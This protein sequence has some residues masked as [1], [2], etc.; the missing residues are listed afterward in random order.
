MGPGKNCTH[1]AASVSSY[2]PD[3]ELHKQTLI[4]LVSIGRVSLDALR[5]GQCDICGDSDNSAG[6]EIERTAG[7][8]KDF[9]LWWNGLC[10]R[11]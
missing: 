6:R 2:T 7:L 10:G 4:C 9:E 1:N 8:V 11:S 5:A 3:P